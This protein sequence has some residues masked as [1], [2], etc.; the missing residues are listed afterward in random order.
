[1]SEGSMQKRQVRVR[2]MIRGDIDAVL[3]I[4]S[5]IAGPGRSLSWATSTADYL[6]GGI[7]PACRVA[8]A[9][10]KIVGF[11][12]G[13]LKGWDYGLPAGG[14]IDVMGVDPYF[15]DLGVGASLVADFE[16]YC[17]KLGANKT[18]LLLRKDD[19][20]I[21]RFFGLQGFAEG[22]YVTWEKSL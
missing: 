13:D 16:A 4:D 7:S 5:R 17:K 20:D 14:W 9:D 3:E 6:A 2:L 19:Q 12:L 11:L 8:E 22:G 18:Y 10:G 21:A 1:M 15:R